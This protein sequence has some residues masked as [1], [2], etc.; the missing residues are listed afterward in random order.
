MNLFFEGNARDAWTSLV[1]PHPAGVQ[2]LFLAV[3]L[4]A[5][6]APR[7][8]WPVFL[9]YLCFPALV[10]EFLWVLLLF[11]LFIITY[12]AFFLR[13]MVFRLLSIIF[14]SLFGRWVLSNPDRSVVAFLPRAILGEATRKGPS[15]I[16][17]FKTKSIHF[18][19][20]RLEAPVHPRNCVYYFSYPRET[21]PMPRG[22]C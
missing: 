11:L 14:S 19:V 6:A 17:R 1:T 5:V 12:V 16:Y 18:K 2:R 22:V 8:A 7:L 20:G 15:P 10:A 13:S 4:S 21:F 3:N 9:D